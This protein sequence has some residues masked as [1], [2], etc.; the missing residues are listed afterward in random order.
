MAAP[1]KQKLRRHGICRRGEAI[2]PAPRA[3]RFAGTADA[4]SIMAARV[5][6]RTHR[7]SAA[8]TPDTTAERNM[9]TQ[10]KD[11]RDDTSGAGQP[12]KGQTF[13]TDISETGDDGT[14]VRQA[15]VNEDDLSETKQ[16]EQK[17]Q[18]QN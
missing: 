16:P 17:D 5:E 14:T 15:E 3:A 11:Q 13:E 12:D 4:L 18:S 10:R 1:T 9:S 6:R 8:H 7:L 2:V